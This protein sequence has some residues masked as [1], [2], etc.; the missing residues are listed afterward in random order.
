MV[1]REDVFNFC[2]PLKVSSEVVF[3]YDRGHVLDNQTPLVQV[4]CCLFQ[5]SPFHEWFA[6]DIPSWEDFQVLE[7]NDLVEDYFIVNLKHTVS[8]VFVW[9]V[10]PWLDFD[11]IDLSEF[12]EEVQDL[13]LGHE[14]W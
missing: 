11:T 10:L 8:S 6:D 13:T 12:T 14:S 4:P 9:I 3:F 5:L 1:E 2:I 7:R